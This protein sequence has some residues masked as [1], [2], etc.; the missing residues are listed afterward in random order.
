[1]GGAEHAGV[2]TFHRLSET[3]TR[4]M[5][6]STGSRPACSRGSVLPSTSTTCR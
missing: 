1:V 4:V 6:R 3:S 5:T 2:V